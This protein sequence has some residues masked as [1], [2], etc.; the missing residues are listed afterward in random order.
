MPHH[1]SEETAPDNLTDKVAAQ[2][3][4]STASDHAIHDE[5]KGPVEGTLGGRSSGG[6]Q[7]V[8]SRSSCTRGLD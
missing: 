2:S 7:I 4:D 8:E 5:N 3:K 1:P 6:P